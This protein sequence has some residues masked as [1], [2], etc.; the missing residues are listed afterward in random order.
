MIICTKKFKT[1]QQGLDQL[2]QIS[3]SVEASIYFYQNRPVRDL[4]RNN[5]ENGLLRNKHNSDFHVQCEGNQIGEMELDYDHLKY[6]TSGGVVYGWSNCK[7]GISF[8]VG[9]H[10]EGSITKEA[11]RLGWELEKTEKSK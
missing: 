10:R 2:C 7:E 9:Y 11:F 5:I 1:F 8:F 3:N 6:E 4:S